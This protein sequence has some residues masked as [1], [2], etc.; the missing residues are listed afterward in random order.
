[1]AY[2]PIFANVDG[3]SCL[4]L[5][6][7][8]VALRRGQALLEAG[9]DVTLMSPR[10]V[11]AL[12]SLARRGKLR[13]L[14]RK[15]A[16]GDVRGFTL[17]YLA[18]D[19]AQLRRSLAN[20]AGEC[21]VAVNVADTPALCSLISAAVMGRGALSVALSTGGCSPAMAK[22][23]RKWLDRSFGEEYCLVIEAHRAARRFL[24]GFEAD[25]ARR[26]LRMT[27]LAAS[28]PPARLRRGEAEGI[29]R[30]L[31]RHVGAGLDRLGFA[32]DR[33]RCD[34]RTEGASS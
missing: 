31:L 8:P 7:R 25:F 26:A 17:G 21:E 28:N 10:R 4:V 22:K 1:M 33:L 16:C 27:R 15:Y 23:I 6:G 2:L 11:S 34:L 19:D 14:A 9:A 32:A 20:D 18:V 12:E 30:I 24:M 29:N 13:L 3:R 5:G